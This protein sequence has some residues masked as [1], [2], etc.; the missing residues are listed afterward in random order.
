MGREGGRERER[1]CVC[2][3]VCVMRTRRERDGTG[4]AGAGQRGTIQ[5]DDCEYDEETESAGTVAN[6][7]K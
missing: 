2:V 1:E 5:C 7:T 4:D 3:C 6:E